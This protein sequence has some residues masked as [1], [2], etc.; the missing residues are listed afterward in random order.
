M[1]YSFTYN[2][3]VRAAKAVCAPTFHSVG[4]VE[5]LGFILGRGIITYIAASDC[6]AVSREEYREIERAFERRYKAA[7]LAR[8][9]NYLEK[10]AEFI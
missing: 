6:V 8:R 7:M 4:G 2:G 5:R 9:A 1:F 10:I 3:Q